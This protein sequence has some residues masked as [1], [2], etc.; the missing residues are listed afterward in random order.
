MDWLK[1]AYE[2]TGAPDHP[3]IALLIFVTLGA[4][5]GL[6]AW[7][8]IDFQYRKEQALTQETT[9][10]QEQQAAAIADIRSILLEIQGARDY[11]MSE[12]VQQ[13]LNDLNE[14]ETSAAES[15]VD[16]YASRKVAEGSQVATTEAANAYRRL[17]FLIVLSDEERASRYFRRAEEL[18]VDTAAIERGIAAAETQRREETEARGDVVNRVRPHLVRLHEELSR[19]L[20]EVWKLL[21]EKNITFALN[22]RQANLE[23]LFNSVLAGTRYEERLVEA[24]FGTNDPTPSD[25]GPYF[26]L[27]V[28]AIFPSGQLVEEIPEDVLPFTLYIQRWKNDMAPGR[29]FPHTVRLLTQDPSG[30]LRLWEEH[31]QNPEETTLAEIVDFILGQ[32]QDEAAWEAAQHYTRR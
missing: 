13:A 31:F 2:A 15:V 14:G 6:L 18:A 4:G 11:G 20:A 16:S 28:T 25:T 7:K 22:P 17:G 24:Y 19:A 32:I 12:A 21:E 1:A 9:L 5:L 3:W 29:T 10:Q 27:W 26:T 23:S 8:L 30:R